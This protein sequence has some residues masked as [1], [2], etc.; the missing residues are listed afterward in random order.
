MANAT[1]GGGVGSWEKVEG[2]ELFALHR[3]AIV[4]PEEALPSM[5]LD[6]SPIGLRVYVDSDTQ[7]TPLPRQRRSQHCESP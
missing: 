2:L 3:L 4:V 1:C 5:V 6:N 7:Q